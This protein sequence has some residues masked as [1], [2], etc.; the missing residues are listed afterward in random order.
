MELVVAI[1]ENN[2]IGLDG[3]MPWHL[4]AD[5]AHFKKITSGHVVLMGR[6]TFDSIGKPLP[7]RTNLV[8]TRNN[9]F[10]AEGV[11]VVHTI[12]DAINESEGNSLFV[13]GGSEI[14]KLAMQHVDV[15]HVTRIHATIEG[16][17]F[18]P[19]ID[20]KEWTL[21][22]SEKLPPDD[23]NPIPMSFETWKRYGV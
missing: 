15:M 17:T 18:F 11:I 10:A 9:A 14:Y 20:E 8:L 1:T 13:I 7:N 5:L 16:D 6:K 22:D 19:P 23:K 4:P 3:D 2:V 12:E 21:M